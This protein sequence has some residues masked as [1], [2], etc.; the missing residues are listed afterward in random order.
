MTSPDFAPG[1]LLK[2]WTSLRSGLVTD[3]RTSETDCAYLSSH[4]RSIPSDPITKLP[5]PL[6]DLVAA[7]AINSSGGSQTNPGVNE[8]IEKVAS[9][10]VETTGSLKVRLHRCLE[11]GHV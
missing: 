11:C 8:W 2:Y 4:L 5:P 3:Y 1:P 10:Q 6:K 7:S 9:G